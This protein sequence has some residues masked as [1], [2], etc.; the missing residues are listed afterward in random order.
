MP[1]IGECGKAPKTSPTPSTTGR[2]AISGAGMAVRV[3][4]VILVLG[5]LV[6]QFQSSDNGLEIDAQFLRAVLLFQLPMVAAN[7]CYAW[8]HA[9][10]VRM[11]PIP[12]MTAIEAIFLSATLNIVTPGRLSEIVKA[13]YLRSRLGV[14]LAHGLSA[15]L[16]ER[17]LDVVM[18]GAIA[19]TGMAALLGVQNGLVV[20]L[21]A[22][23]LLALFTMRPLA[24]L[25]IGPLSRCEGL[26]WNFIERQ[27]R[28]VV[29]VLRSDI[30]LRSALLTVASWVMHFAALIIFFQQFPERSL[31][32]PDIALV[33]GA[34]VLA[35][36]IPAL[37]AGLGAF[38]A[39]VVL[40]LQSRGFE[41]GHAL[42]IAVT[43]H[44]AELLPAALLGPIVM[45][46]RS[47]GI[48][49]LA[50][51]ALSALKASRS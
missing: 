3:G 15:I 2:G 19:A 36:A 23:G 12:L 51:D 20:F 35:G 22:I 14:P 50:R 30:A 26:I 45:L 7:L 21:P 44:I 27:C 46:R 43:L 13:T 38:E 10:L 32:L 41:F 39:A 42:G 34:I 28:H 6:Q 47:M 31:S 8:R 33:F 1:E 16:I 25:L 11:P 18:V 17:L 4:L 29:D 9:I 49:H 48:G 24:A 37:P 5:L 40:V